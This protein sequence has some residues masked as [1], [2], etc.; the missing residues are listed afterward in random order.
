MQGK[1]IKESVQEGKIL[2]ADGAWG[3]ALSN[4]GI[5]PGECPELWCLDHAEEVL[6]I[7]EKYIQA[8]ADI[9]QT[10]SFGGNRYK[11]AMFDLDDRVDDINEAAAEISRRAAGADTWVLASIGPTGKMVLTGEVTESDLEEA[12]AQQAGALRD[13]GADAFCIETMSAVDEACA[14][15]RGVK[16]VAPDHE[17]IVTFT[18]EKSV[19]GDY[20]TMMGVDPQEAA[21]SAAEA[22]A[23]IIGSNCGN[24]L[25]GMID[26]V[27]SIR[28]L[29][30]DIPIL[31][32]GNAG[33]PKNVDGRDVFPE[34]PRD[35]AQHVKGL[36]EAGASIIGGCCGTTP[37][38]IAAL[39]KEIDALI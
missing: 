36:V 31:V 20:K 27:R 37:G 29:F 35:M 7:A 34:G 26:I 21:S 13:G 24:G 32:N 39:R 18:F 3:T 19:R 17:V 6:D 2:L 10:N 4:K 11:L 14:A 9:I 22:G 16:T 15:I 25:A 23:D 30:E 1:T 5:Q 12:F 8:G 28:G 38:H 33:M